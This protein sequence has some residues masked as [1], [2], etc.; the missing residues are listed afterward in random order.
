MA[1]QHL[2]S[3]QTK[4]QSQIITEHINEIIGNR[5]SQEWFE[6]PS[7][8]FIYI[9]THEIQC[10]KIR[11]IESCARGHEKKGENCVHEHELI[12]CRS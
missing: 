11:Y 12:D 6:F 3:P 7:D 1:N 5:N 9:Y 2:T 4:K 8:E 10:I